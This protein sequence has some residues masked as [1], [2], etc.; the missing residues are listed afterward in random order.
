M[1]KIPATS[2]YGEQNSARRT[3][4][5]RLDSALRGGTIEASKSGPWE[6]TDHAVQRYIER[7]RRGLPYDQA[8]GEIVYQSH[9]AHFVKALPS[10]LE[11]WRGPKPRRLRFRVDPSRDGGKPRLVTVLFAF[12]RC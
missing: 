5:H 11:L 2:D 1:T 8:L 7:V 3:V 4:E 10:G 9:H 6:V 12:D